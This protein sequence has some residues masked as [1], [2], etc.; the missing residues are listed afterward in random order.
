MKRNLILTG[1][2]WLAA[3][4]S[5][6]DVTGKWQGAFSFNDQSVPLTFEL[7]GAPRLRAR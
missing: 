2:F 6:A 4:A 1:L 3:L 5:A 7:K